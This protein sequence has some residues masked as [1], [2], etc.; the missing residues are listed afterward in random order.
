MWH[1]VDATGRVMTSRLADRPVNPASVIKVATTLWA[2]E[3]LGPTHRFTTRFELHGSFDERSGTLDGDLVVRGGADPDFQVENAFLVARRLNRFG[4]RE[5]TGRL[6]V[7]AEFWI[8]WEGG[9]ARKERSAARRRELMATRLRRALDPH[10]WDPATRDLFA[11]FEARHAGAALSPGSVVVRGGIGGPTDVTPGRVASVEHRSNPLVVT[12]KRFNAYSNN[13]IER[14]GDS[15]GSPVE[16]AA[17]LG[18]RVKGSGPALRIETLSGLGSNRLTSRQIVRLFDDLRSTARR[19]DTRVQDLL[20]IAGCDPGTL[21]KFPRLTEIQAGELVA[22][23]GTL[24]STDGGVSALA[25]FGRGPQGPVTFC[26]VAP[27]S[28]SRLNR[29]RADQES[30]LLELLSPDGLPRR[31]SCGEPVVFSDDQASLRTIDFRR[32]PGA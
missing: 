31:T 14:L 16:L 23:T 8:G 17:F 9:S 11:E 26:V 32:K 5:V 6:R 25:G 30:W 3:T 10:R 4:V 12:L 13:D 19:L 28:G 27:R 22:K 20:P 2:L 29:A 1:A 18:P 15:L 24:G 21:E 7:D